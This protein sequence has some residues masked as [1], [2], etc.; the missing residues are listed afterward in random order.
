MTETD[1]PFRERSQLSGHY[2]DHGITVLVEIFRQSGSAIWRMEVT[3]LDKQVTDWNEPF[4]SAQEAWDEFIH[5]V[6]TED[7]AV[8]L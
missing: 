7:I 8:F 6:N 2:T 4:A 3:S 5:V 1:P